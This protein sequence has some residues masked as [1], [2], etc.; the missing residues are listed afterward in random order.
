MRTPGDCIGV[1]EVGLKYRHSVA[2][3]A[4]EGEKVG[5]I[6]GGEDGGVDTGTEITF[7]LF[8]SAS[9]AVNQSNPT[10]RG[11]YHHHHHHHHHYQ[12]ESGP[13]LEQVVT[14]QKICLGSSPPSCRS[15]CGS[16]SSS[17]Q[18][19]KERASIGASCDPPKDLSGF[20]ATKLQIQVRELLVV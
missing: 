3:G 5:G 11:G 9:T 7:L 8:T 15:K 17:K 4:G 10:Q 1:E 12:G 13:A 6:G 14:H 20:I 18:K 2:V 16:C 19:R